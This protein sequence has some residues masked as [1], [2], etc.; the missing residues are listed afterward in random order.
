MTRHKHDIQPSTRRH[1]H[2]VANAVTVLV[3][4]AAAASSF[5][6]FAGDSHASGGASCSTRPTAGTSAAQARA[7]VAK[8]VGCALKG[9]GDIAVS[10]KTAEA[11]ANAVP[12]GAQID[13][14]K[15][16]V[17]FSGHTIHFTV[18]ASPPTSNMKYRIAGLNDPTIIIPKGA[19]VSVEFINGDSDEAH[20]WVLRSLT[21]N[22]PVRHAGAR[23]LG[24]PTNA[25]QPAEAINFTLTNPGTYEYLCGFPG[26][27]AMGMHG[28][29]IVEN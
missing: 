6:V 18:L 2:P 16:T 27:A 4:A 26:H 7:N 1:R 22:G 29:L 20:M 14:A 11:A 19:H 5:A 23:P 21:T 28:T 10:L 15:N 25:G 8:Y 12:A 17:R 24:D 9:N 13:K 3:A